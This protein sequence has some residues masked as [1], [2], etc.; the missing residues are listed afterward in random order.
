MMTSSD[1][2]LKLLQLIVT[3]YQFIHKLVW[4]FEDV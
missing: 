3:C 1:T 4:I 2:D